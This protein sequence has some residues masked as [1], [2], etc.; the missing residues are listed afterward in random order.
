VK[1]IQQMLPRAAISII[2]VTLIFYCLVLFLNSAPAQNKE[3][4]TKLPLIEQNTFV[5]DTAIPIGNG[6]WL[7]DAA[8][9]EKD[10]GDG[11]YWRPELGKYHPIT[12]TVPGLFAGKVFTYNAG[13]GNRKKINQIYSYAATPE[14][15]CKMPATKDSKTGGLLNCSA[16]NRVDW[17]NGE[18]FITR[19]SAEVLKPTQAY[20]S[21]LTPLKQEMN[22]DFIVIPVV[23]GRLDQG[24]NGFET[25][26]DSLNSF[27][28]QQAEYLAEKTA[29]LFCTSNDVPSVQFDIEPF[30]FDHPGQAFYY[31][32]LAFYFSGK[33]DPLINDKKEQVYCKNTKYPYGR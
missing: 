25:Y 16:D 23:D 26:L 31:E 13:A 2:V 15:S 6:S 3:S 21:A 32:K 12:S 4:I 8:F 7:Y 22:A 20:L 18:I 5:K 9:L 28:Q 29:A 10:L 24:V 14:T 30:N 27:N 1:K 33:G 11:K 19:N 17:D